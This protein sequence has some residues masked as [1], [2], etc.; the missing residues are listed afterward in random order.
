MV[1]HSARD[2]ETPGFDNYTGYGILDA[3]AA[4]KANPNFF[5]ESRISGVKVVR[6]QGKNILRILGTA[7]ADKFGHAVILLGKGK[8]PKKWL[9]VKRRI[10][11]PVTDGSLM[12]IPA[13]VFRGAKKW[14]IRLIT[15]HKN[16]SKREARFTLTLG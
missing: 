13:K 16:K 11:A 12:D 10:K 1:L 14:T 9:R 3:S 15:T 6:K 7:N 5:V 2:I 8:A 4:L